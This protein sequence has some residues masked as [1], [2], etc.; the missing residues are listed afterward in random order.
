MDNARVLAVRLLLRCEKDGYA[1]LVLK[2]ALDKQTLSPQDRQFVSAL[3][4]GTLEKQRLL[5][6]LLQPCLKKNL[7][8]LDA[9]VRAILRSGL[10]QCRYMDSVP[11]YA[12]VHAAVDL[13][14][15]FGKSSAAGLVNAVLRRAAAADVASLSFP[16][17]ITRLGT[18]Y[19]VSDSL[20]RMLQSAYPARAQQILQAFETPTPTVLRANTLRTTPEELCVALQTEQIAAR[21]L[22]LPGAVLLPQGGDIVHT[23]AFRQ[24]LFHVQGLASQL[25]ALAL[26]AQP[27]QTV[28]DVCAA[29]GGKSVTLAQ[30]MQNR[31]RLVCGELQP[32]RLS[33]IRSQLARCGVTCAEV[34][35]ADAAVPRD[36]LPAA[37]A[38]L[39]DVPCSGSGVLSRKPDIRYKDLD[40]ARDQLTALQLRILCTAA[41]YLRA[42]GSLVYAT[43][44]LDPAENQAVVEAFLQ[45]EPRF[46]PQPLP[47]SP[48]VLPPERL[49]SPY[50]VTLFPSAAGNDGFFVAKLKKM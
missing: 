35:C 46:Q 8:A 6:A 44:S 49:E 12:A 2:S 3:V 9:P 29:P 22:P 17:A 41:G 42:G 30:Q 32:A 4:Y 21:P 28:L 20:V 16:D 19:N 24:G 50:G 25:A 23:A 33:L 13:T 14:R 40:A 27:G 43:C 15:R 10:Y 7:A 47:F 48:D 31:G 45:A 34:L 26:E 36:D 1:N 37:D 39:C 18:L 11:E 38:V 5:D